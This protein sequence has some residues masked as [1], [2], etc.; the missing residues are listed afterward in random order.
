MQPLHLHEIINEARSTRY[1]S[2]RS[3]RIFASNTLLDSSIG[4]VR[5]D[6]NR[7]QQVLWNLLSNAVKFTPHGGRIQVDARTRE[8]ARRDRRW[9][10]RGIGIRSEFLPYVFDRFRQADPSTT[11]RY[12][13]LGLGLSIVKNLV[14]LHGGSVRVKSPGREPGQHVRR[15]AAR[16]ARSRGGG[17]GAL[18]ATQSDPLE[19]IELPR[20]DSVR[21]L[22]VDDEADGRA[23]IARISAKIAAR[24]PLA[25]P[26]AAEAL[27]HLAQE[28]FDVLLSDI[29]MPD[30]DGYELMR[31][32]GAEL[33]VERKSAS[34]RSRSR[35]TRGPR[36]GS[37]PCSPAI[38]CI[39]RSR[40][41][42]GSSSQESR[43]CC[44]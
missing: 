38:T 10:T 3:R 37:A 17:Y 26:S 36:T 8:L 39:S 33:G 20:L 41:K 35:R 7:L 29:G 1:A 44:G 5:G 30:M 42:R 6:P 12:G 9:K 40:S 43:A 11:R 21:V 34:R 4:L 27:R 13:G 22:V 16:V 28:R 23:L 32:V 18:T 14:E 25:R 2:R 24:A 19:A 15:V 31:R